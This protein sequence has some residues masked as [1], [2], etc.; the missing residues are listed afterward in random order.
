[1]IIGSVCS[2]L[3]GG[4]LPFLSFLWGN[5]TN[6]FSNPQEMV[7]EALNIFID[8]LIFGGVAIFAGWGM[9]YLWM[10]AGENQAN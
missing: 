7:N 4:S 10:A 8:Y 1:M 3:I 9:H 6:S 5:I 2:A